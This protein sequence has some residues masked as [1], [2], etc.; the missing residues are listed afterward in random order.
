M[1]DL[2]PPPPDPAIS[3]TLFFLFLPALT[4][5]LIPGPDSPECVSPV[6]WIVITAQENPINTALCTCS[7]HSRLAASCPMADSDENSHAHVSVWVWGCGVGREVCIGLCSLSVHIL[8]GRE[9]SEVGKDRME[10]ISGL[11]ASFL[12]TV[13]SK[14]AEGWLVLAGQGPG[15]WRVRGL[16]TASPFSMTHGGVLHPLNSSKASRFPAH[17]FVSFLP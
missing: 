1:K 14:W 3:Q 8:R 15:E 4:P 5:T 17:C 16:C 11:G 6:S 7:S 10:Q 9:P 2:R 13:V 12:G